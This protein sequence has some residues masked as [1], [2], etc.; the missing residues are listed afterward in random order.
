MPLVRAL[1][2]QPRGRNLI[3]IGP[4]AEPRAQPI[5][6]IRVNGAASRRREANPGGKP[7]RNPRLTQR[8]GSGTSEA[9]FE[10]KPRESHSSDVM[11]TVSW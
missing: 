10:A 8:Q 5:R 1:P 6:Q 7:L 3:A 2:N 11:K 4:E 9:T